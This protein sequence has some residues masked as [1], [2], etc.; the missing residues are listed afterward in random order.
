MEFKVY[1]GAT[2]A[3]PEVFFKLEESTTGSI[4]LVACDGNGKRVSQGTLL[5]IGPDGITL[6]S[7]VS[8]E[9]GLPVNKSKQV[10]VTNR[11]QP[12]V[13]DKARGFTPSKKY[14]VEGTGDDT[15]MLFALDEDGNKVER[16]Y[17][18]TI[19]NGKVTRN[20]CVS[21]KVGVPLDED[22]RIIIN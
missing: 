18:L 12:A 10:V 11:F 22:S 17:M 21:K 4:L 2:K 20:D 8:D 1:N 5:H 15:H 9:L 13:E 6:I 14:A 16:G 7:G 19:G 3:K